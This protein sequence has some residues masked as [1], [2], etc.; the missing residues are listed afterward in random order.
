MNIFTNY[1]TNKYKSFDDQDSP[2]INDQKNNKC[3]KKT[4]FKKNVKNGKTAHDY[5]NL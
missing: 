2:W 3:N 1:I 5:K 4:L